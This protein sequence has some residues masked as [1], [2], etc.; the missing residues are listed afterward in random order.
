MPKQDAQTQSM[1]SQQAAESTRQRYE[2]PTVEMLDV[3]ATRGAKIPSPTES[4]P[5][6]GS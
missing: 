2:R 6:S 3:G 1:N 4:S 5:T